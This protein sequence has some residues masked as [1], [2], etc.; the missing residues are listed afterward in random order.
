MT[1][2]KLNPILAELRG[3]MGDLVFKRYGNRVVV[4]RKPDMLQ[5]KPSQAQL[6][7][8]A[9]FR[10]A[11]GYCRQALADPAAR[12]FYAVVATTR[13]K[14]INSVAVADYLTMRP[15]LSGLI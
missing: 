2:V 6:A 5:V 3:Q 4:S 1:Q 11:M 9:R 8:R 7:Q 13:H 14:P 12:A 15:W 10:Q